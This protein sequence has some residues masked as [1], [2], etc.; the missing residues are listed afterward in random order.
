MRIGMRAVIALSILLAA[1]CHKKQPVT[2]V[3]SSS[4]PPPSPTPIPSVPAPAPSAVALE[5]ANRAFFLG[6]YDSAGREYSRYLELIPL[7]GNR[8]EA[9]FRL[10][11][12]HTLPGRQDWA[13]AG[14]F[15]NQLLSEFPQSPLRPEA[16]LILSLREQSV[17][18]SA[19]ASRLTNE[20][21][22]LQGE[23]AQL[24]SNAAQSRDQLTRLSTEIDQLKQK[25]IERE[26]RIRQ[27]NADLERLIRLDTNRPRPQL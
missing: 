3:P 22:Q 1:G 10:G 16:Q 4:P 12:I 25:A 9:L 27:L 23:V 2:T 7:A 26:E 20:A 15:L 13:R 17:Q 5:A 24:K 14:S 6:D 18:L 8:G 19:D 21:A 11:L